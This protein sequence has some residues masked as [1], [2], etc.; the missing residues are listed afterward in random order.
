MPTSSR[1]TCRSRS[2]RRSRT[3]SCARNH[4]DPDKRVLV[5]AD[6][7][8]LRLV[9]DVQDEGEPLRPRRQH[10][11]CDR[12]REPRARG[13]PRAVPDA[14]AHGPRRA[15][16]RE[17]R[18]RTA[19]SCGSSLSARMS[20]L[21]EVLAAFHEATGCD[22][23]VWRRDGGVQG[24]APLHRRHAGA[25]IRRRPELLPA[26]RR[27]RA[28]RPTRARTARRRADRRPATRVARARSLSHRAARDRQLSQVPAAGRRAVSPEHARGRA[29]G[30]R[31][32][33][34]VRGDQPPLHHQR[35]P[36]PHGL[37]RGGRRD[38]PARGQRDGRRAASARSSSTIRDSHTLRVVARLGGEEEP[39]RPISR[40]RRVQRQRA[41]L[42][43]AALDHRRGRRDA[44]ATPSAASA[45][46]RCSPCRSCG[47]R[48][49][50]A[51][52]SAS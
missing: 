47:R 33:R 35:D 7:D 16:R 6:V 49:T 44:R 3:R 24:P 42:P 28:T 22:A 19:T 32:R 23:S 29:R 21:G 52:R 46:A 27:R 40:R 5:R 25:P 1:S 51:S 13:R 10:P 18:R 41:R 14:R 38:D 12:S 11:R 15:L 30:Q 4:E 36:R 8:T 37:P 9:V 26:A 17:R 2:A 34:A 50:V 45:R 31:A 20:E 39:I 43:H 48:R